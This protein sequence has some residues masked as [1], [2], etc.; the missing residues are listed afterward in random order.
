VVRLD[1]R[2]IG[3]TVIAEEGWTSVVFEALAEE[4]ENVLSVEFTNDVYR[5]DLGQDRNVFLGETEI[6]SLRAKP[7]S[8]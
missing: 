4:G 5:P 3:R 6:L 1:G 8:S 7:G 2:V